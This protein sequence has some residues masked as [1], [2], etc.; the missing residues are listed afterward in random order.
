VN[1]SKLAFIAIVASLGLFTNSCGDYQGSVEG[2]KR[3]TVVGQYADILRA[4]HP[5]EGVLDDPSL[6]QVTNRFGP[7]K[8]DLKKLPIES[9]VHEAPVKPWSSWWFPHSDSFIFEGD[10]SPLSKY[11]EYVEYLFD[12][13]I[14]IGDHPPSASQWAAGRHNARAQTWE[15]LCNAWAMASVMHD[16]PINDITIS[17]PRTFGTKKI[18]FTVA[19]QKALL[20][21]TYEGVL[22]ED[23]S[24]Y[25]QKFTGDYEG[26][27]HPDLFPD[28]LHRLIEHEFI[29]NQRLVLMDHDAGVQVWTVP[30]HKVNYR[31]TALPGKRNAVKVTMW[32][33][34]VEPIMDPSQKD[35][36]GT[37]Q[38]MREYNYILYG[39]V[40]ANGI[41]TVE[42]GIWFTNDMGKDSRYDH[43]D[44]FIVIDSP[45]TLRRQSFNPGIRSGIVDLILLGYQM[46]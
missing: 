4:A 46:N 1:H 29:Q 26:W 16:E 39:D 23:L 44:Y 33:Y 13:E 43:P 28:Q 15:G 37:K 11:D 36:H 8:I 25:G 7:S 5:N 30:I 40:D 21:K 31:I 24:F 3:E 2:T 27:I 42:S 20:L 19:D 22:D 6:Y 38:T 14:F 18:E 9:D 45:E 32:L 34:S 41:M 17:I 12:K 10:E 35:F